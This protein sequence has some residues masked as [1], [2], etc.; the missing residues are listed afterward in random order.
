ME[1]PKEYMAD[2][3]SAT[4]EILNTCPLCDARDFSFFL[5]APDFLVTRQEFQ[6]VKCQNC[7]LLFTNP[8][9]T[10]ETIGL[11][12][13]SQ[14]YISHSNT[15][16]SL[17]AKLYQVVRKYTIRQKAN[18]IRQKI[19]SPTHLLDVGCGTGE[20]LSFMEKKGWIVTGIEPS[21]K[22]RRYAQ[23]YYR[24]NIFE[25]SYLFDLPEKSYEVI[26]LWH[27]LEHLHRVNEYLERLKKLLKPD[28]FLI[29]ALPNSQ[30]AEARYYGSYWAAYDLPR[31]LYHFSPS[32]L[33]HL[34]KKHRIQVLE[35]KRMLF[36]AFY[37]ALLSE[38]YQ[39]HA[40]AYLRAFGC[41]FWSNLIALM[42]IDRC[43]SL[44]YICSSQ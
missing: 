5:Q 39:D 32:T 40:L 24:L 12:Y 15:Q 16:A 27:V 37:V 11:Y 30:A 10:E 29:L 31:H 41:G 28:G 3:Y 20:F 43:S 18:L 17:L 23:K 22:A 25:P 36:D 8:R 35:K 44:I 21:E 26:T 6:I 38:R 14:E 1:I 33:Q 7:N 13:E 19:S 9:P 4:L 42:N 2:F 34:L